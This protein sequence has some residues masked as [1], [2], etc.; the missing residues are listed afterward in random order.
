[1]DIEDASEEMGLVTELVALS[2]PLSDILAELARLHL[3]ADAELVRL[4]RRHVISVLERY[5]AGELTADD[6][7]NWAD[8]VDLQDAIGLAEDDQTLSDAVFGLANPP[9]ARPLTPERARE[10]LA[11][12]RG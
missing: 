5:L 1:M 3:D 11:S 9:A 10:L 2:R 4:E 7:E 8:A 6:V 12:L